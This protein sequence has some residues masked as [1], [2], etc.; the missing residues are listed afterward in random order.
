[1]TRFAASLRQCAGVVGVA[2]LLLF[3]SEF[4]FFNESM[5]LQLVD[6]T[7]SARILVLTEAL[8]Y[9]SLFAMPML[10]ALSW[11]GVCTWSGLFLAGCLYGWAA[12]AALI[13][14]VYENLP[15]SY[16]WPSISWHVLVDVFA[17]LVLMPRMLLAR[18]W[19]VAPLSFLGLGIAWGY[20]TTWIVAADVTLS[21]AQFAGY[22]PWAFALVPLGLFL[23][24][25]SGQ[26][27]G[28][29]NRTVPT[30]L[31]L[32]LVGLGVWVA[33]A[34]SPMGGVGLAVLIAGC[35]ILLRAEPVWQSAQLIRAPR[36]NLRWLWLIATP[37]SAFLT[38]ETVMQSGFP[39]ADVLFLPALFVASFGAIALVLLIRA[40]LIL[41]PRPPG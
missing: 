35:L 27:V 38:Y 39:T 29:V 14:L 37:I 30:V 41:L 25:L 3:F 33:L 17:G 10:A 36:P 22:A 18:G 11:F 2:A 40:R 28:H 24:S 12:E 16:V 20:W 6:T 8:F 21:P 19:L 13:P 23:M 31:S 1:V 34:T 32:P 5:A 4:F 7:P 15:F 26:S 9:Y